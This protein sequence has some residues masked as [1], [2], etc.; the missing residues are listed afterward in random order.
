[1]SRTQASTNDGL[2]VATPLSPT[3]SDSESSHPAYPVAAP[4]SIDAALSSSSESPHPP[5]F[6]SLYFPSRTTADQQ[7][8]PADSPEDDC[9]PAFAPAPPFTE[10]SSSA[11]ATAVAETKAALPRDTKDGS[12][13]KDI[14]DGEPPPPYSEGSSPLESFTY[15]MAS[16]G[17]PASIITQVSQSSA[18][19]PINTLGGSD[20]NITLE[21]RG[22]R[23]TLSRDELLTLPEFVL[24]SL[25]PNGLL[26]DG[27]MN[28]YHDGDVYPVDYDPNSLQYMLE[29]FRTVAQT[30]PA[31]PPSPT[32]SSDHPA[33]A[34][35]IEPMHGSARDMLQDRAG[36]IVLREDL[37]F[38]AIPPHRDIT[39]PEMIEVKR[40]AGEA[41]LRQ[42]GIF[43]GLRKSEEP[44]D[45][46]SVV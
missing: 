14:D 13:S 30:I 10:S 6:S 41:L 11:A 21:L 2:S 36:I 9:P 18:G 33:E 27:H 20:E 3:D 4:A 34:V 1:M 24:L 7:H 12:S 42:D 45:R 15:V 16:A 44:G 28:S 29:F 25:F 35:P 46:K 17:G 39:Q 19:P 23:F 43:S 37:D 32:A 22:T 5:P 31:S 8:K 38:Y 40:A 26:P